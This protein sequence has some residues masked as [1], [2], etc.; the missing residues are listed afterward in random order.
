M[1]RSRD[2][3]VE[4]WNGLHLNMLR[5]I[6]HIKGR[7]VSLRNHLRIFETVNGGTELSQLF[8]AKKRDYSLRTE[9]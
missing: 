8:A 7:R 6:S 4:V 5:L 9:P 3:N 2:L 1:F